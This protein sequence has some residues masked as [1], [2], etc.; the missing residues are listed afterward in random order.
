MET[1]KV[2]TIEEIRVALAAAANWR[3]FMIFHGIKLVGFMA[4]CGLLI[5]GSG[6]LIRGN[7]PGWAYP[8]PVGFSAIVLPGCLKEVRH[9]SRMAKEFQAAEQRA[10]TGAVVYAHEVPSLGRRAAA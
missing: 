5:L 2:L 9:F 1:R 8:L 6:Y 3:R 7:V 10:L 4:S